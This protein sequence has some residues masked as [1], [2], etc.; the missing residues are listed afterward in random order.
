VID[1][2]IVVLISSIMPTIK[3]VRVFCKLPHYSK[4]VSVCVAVE[5]YWQIIFHHSLSLLVTEPR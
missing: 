2:L 3:V 5:L 1:N 4:K